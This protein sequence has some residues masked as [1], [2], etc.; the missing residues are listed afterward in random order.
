[1]TTPDQ[2]LLHLATETAAELSARATRDR[3]SRVNERDHLQPSC[4]YAARAVAALWAPRSELS[5]TVPLASP[6]W[7]RVGRFDIAFL[8]PEQKPVAVELKCGTGRDAIAACAW[9]V[10]K[11]AFALQTG[12]ISAGYLMAATTSAE[13]GRGTRGAELFDTGS[14]DAQELRERFVDWWKVW[15][16][17]GYP[18]A[19]S[20]PRASATR[21][22][23]QIPFRI[24]D[25]SWELRVAA[26]GV[27]T[28]DRVPWEP[29]LQ[30]EA[31][32]TVTRLAAPRSSESSRPLTVEHDTDEHVGVGSI[33]ELADEGGERMEVEI[34][35]VG[36]VSPDSPLGSALLGAKVGEAVDVEAPSGSWK[37]RVL[38]I[39]RA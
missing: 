33:V 27:E 18:A 31:A 4:L 10:L 16:R 14:I 17:D 11:L 19:T 23:C 28:T 2:L 32:Q 13:W 39:R 7:P 21:A 3:L 8:I 22:V 36:G 6:A 37:A 29:L 25:D 34:S 26:V 1:M 5:T 35:A 24:G 30:A 12:V 20:V 15:E 38:A 9:D